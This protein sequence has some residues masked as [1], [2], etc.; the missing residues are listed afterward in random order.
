VIEEVSQLARWPDD[1][2]VAYVEEKAERLVGRGFQSR[3]FRVLNVI[4]SN[5]WGEWRTHR[6]TVGLLVE[7]V[8][9]A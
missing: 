7:M 8:V 4:V 5:D 6:H 2:R 1:E 9:K 3:F